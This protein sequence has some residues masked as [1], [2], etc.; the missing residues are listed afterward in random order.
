M[1]E[2]VNNSILY[3]L[4]EKSFNKKY[5]YLNIFEDLVF[6]DENDWIM[7]SPIKNYLFKQSYEMYF[8]KL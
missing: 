6:F 5:F 3:N 7:E 8:K 1:K 2:I 4:F